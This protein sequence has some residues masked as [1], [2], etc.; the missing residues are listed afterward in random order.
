MQDS[1]LPDASATRIMPSW[2]P[3]NDSSLLPS[4]TKAATSQLASSS[5]QE[6]DSSSRS[7][8]GSLTSREMSVTA[9]STHSRDSF[10]CQDNLCGEP[11]T[12]STG[13]LCSGPGK[14]NCLKT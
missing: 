10:H 8:S 5:A 6:G 11:M 3:R 4:N 1:E 7:S 2:A 12:T 13:E 9:A 14:N